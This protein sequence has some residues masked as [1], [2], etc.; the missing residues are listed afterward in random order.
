MHMQLVLYVTH[1]HRS[2]RSAAGTNG[3]RSVHSATNTTH[4]M[5]CR[6]SFWNLIL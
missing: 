6:L 3:N 2:M 1:E 5:S 4:H